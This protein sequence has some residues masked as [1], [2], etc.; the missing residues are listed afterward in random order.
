MPFTKNFP[1]TELKEALEYWYKKQ[2][3]K[4]PMNM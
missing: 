1:L 4:L 3:V 2:K